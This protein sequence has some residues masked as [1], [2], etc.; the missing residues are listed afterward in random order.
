[1]T[2]CVSF[3]RFLCLKI[4]D[5]YRWYWAM[6][7]TMIKSIEGGQVARSSTKSQKGPWKLSAIF[8]FSFSF[9]LFLSFLLLRLNDTHTHTHNHQLDRCRQRDTPALDTCVGILL[10]SSRRIVLY[11]CIFKRANKEK[12]GKRKKEKSNLNE[13]RDRERYHRSFV[14]SC[15]CI[16][17]YR[18]RGTSMYFSHIMIQWQYILVLIV[19]LLYNL[20]RLVP[21]LCNTLV[22]E[23]V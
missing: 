4:V 20:E 18:C 21:F 23:F 14:R 6:I 3:Q 15:E 2:S 22:V 8:F 7:T 12:C 16:L 11:R 19:I 17:T 13:S 10:L 5:R 9:F 1:M